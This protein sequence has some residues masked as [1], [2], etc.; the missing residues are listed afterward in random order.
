MRQ[1]TTFLAA[2]LLSG[3]A[4]LIDQIPSFNDA[5]QSK[6]IIDV[7]LAVAELDCAKAQAPQV[8]AIKARLDWFR[9]Y[10]ESKARQA[11][12]LRLTE[13]IRDTVDDFYKRV[14]AEGHKDNQVHCQLKKRVL[15][16]QTKRAA[17]VVIGRF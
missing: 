1:I 6:A 10:S 3:C 4:S 2:L 7:R 17:E 5:N 12:V 9:A 16:E 8:Q 14:S 13:P 15:T 11:D